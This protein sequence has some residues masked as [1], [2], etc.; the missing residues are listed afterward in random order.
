M[1]TAIEIPDLVMLAGSKQLKHVA[2]RLSFLPE[3]FVRRPT[4]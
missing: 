2:P 1:D 3:S 4:N